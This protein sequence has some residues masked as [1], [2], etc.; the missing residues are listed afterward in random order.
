MTAR[1][2]RGSHALSD[3]SSQ[4]TAS[5]HQIRTTI[6][7]WTKF[8]CELRH[9]MLIMY[10]EDKPDSWMGTIILSGG[11]VM[12]RP[13]RKEGY[14]WKFF[15][16]LRPSIHAQRVRLS[17]MLPKTPDT[18]KSL[19]ETVGDIRPTEK[20]PHKRVL[21]RVSATFVSQ[22]KTPHAKYSAMRSAVG[23]QLLSSP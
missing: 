5:N 13:S 14:S 17:H 16:P 6:H 8:Y 7:T 11:S 19:N 1:G 15:H 22:K 12:E 18:Q 4:N 20:Y 21:V 10:K 2:L 9:G 23:P 3:S